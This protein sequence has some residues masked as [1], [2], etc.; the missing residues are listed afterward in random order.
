MKSAFDAQA[1]KLTRFLY[2]TLPL[3]LLTARHLRSP[4]V[5]SSPPR[6]RRRPNLRF[7]KISPTAI[8]RIWIF[9]FHFELG[10]FQ[11]MFSMRK[12]EA[13]EWIA[14]Y[15]SRALTKAVAWH[16]LPLP[17]LPLSLSTLLP[18]SSTSAQFGY[19]VGNKC[20][21]CTM[22]AEG[23]T[24]TTCACGDG[25]GERERRGKLTR[26]RILPHPTSSPFFLSVLSL[27]GIRAPILHLSPYSSSS[28]YPLPAA[29]L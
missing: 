21:P 26:P 4:G 17:A 1:R 18:S 6:V 16:P 5:I 29:F 13:S 20:F 14:L 22:D 23:G 3:P 25:Q 10:R 12:K 28:I 19:S 7:K 9:F 27:S 2:G 24:R 11:S 8:S 15:P